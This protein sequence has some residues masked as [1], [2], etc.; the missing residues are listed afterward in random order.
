LVPISYQWSPSQ[1]EEK[2]HPH[3][4]EFVSTL[5]RSSKHQLFLRNTS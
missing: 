4:R 3:R 1:D 2:A 5:L